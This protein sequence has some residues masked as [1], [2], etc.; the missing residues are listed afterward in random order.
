MESGGGGS[1]AVEWTGGEWRVG[2][3]GW[4]HTYGWQQS[5]SAA[6]SP[7]PPQRESEVSISSHL[8]SSH[9]G[10]WHLGRWHLGR[11][12]LGRGTGTVQDEA[13]AA[14][15]RKHRH[16]PHTSHSRQAI[17]LPRAWRRG[18]RSGHLLQVGRSLQPRGAARFRQGTQVRMGGEGGEGLWRGKK[19][20]A[21]RVAPGMPPQADHKP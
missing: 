18:R 8:G 12:H 15:Q 16:R 1:Y 4:A 6:R 5:P 17:V 2:S 19:A 3:C 7:S 9:L 13:V 10:S 11:W 20:A 21:A 14:L